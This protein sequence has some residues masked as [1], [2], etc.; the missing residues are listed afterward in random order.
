[1]LVTAETCP[2]ESITTLDLRKAYLGVAVGVDGHRIRPILMRGDEKLE[3]VFVRR[4]HGRV[5]GAAKRG[6]CDHVPVGT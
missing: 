1:V 4:R 6:V 3:Q 2:V 5:G